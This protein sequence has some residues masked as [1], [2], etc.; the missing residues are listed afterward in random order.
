M[1]KPGGRTARRTDTLLRIAAR[2][3][4]E[5]MARPI[6][7]LAAAISEELYQA[8]AYYEVFAPSGSDANLIQRVS[9]AEVHPGFNV[10]SESL[11]L[12]TILALCRLWDKPSEAAH[13]PAAASQLRR[14][15]N[16][17]DWVFDRQAIATWLSDV[18]AVEGCERLKVLREFRH[19]GLA[20][21]AS[22][23]RPDHVFEKKCAG[24]CMVMSG[25]CLT[26]P[27]IS[28]IG[29]TRS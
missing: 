18:Q 12:G 28:S 16:D 24:S 3:V 22:P 4:S 9:A 6:V 14:D 5:N 7:R 11:Q 26:R 10:I 8:I 27:W 19:V 17:D 29:S 13:I 23:N 21:R 25:G 2:S 1:S 20:H 15:I